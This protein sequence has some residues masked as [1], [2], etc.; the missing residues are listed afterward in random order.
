MFIQVSRGVALR[1]T[2]MFVR[3]V[4]RDVALLKL[5]VTCV[6][7]PVDYSRLKTDYTSKPSCFSPPFLL[8][9]LLP[10]RASRT[11]IIKENANTNSTAS[12]FG[13]AQ[14]PASH[15]FCGSSSLAPL[16]TFSTTSHY[17]CAVLLLLLLC[18]RHVFAA[19]LR[20]NGCYA[21]HPLSGCVS[22][23]SS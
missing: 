9:R 20:E 11:S 15:Y 21:N 17:H 2:C 6:P 3:Q 1:S 8:A 10:H 7:L 19:N 18:L 13:Q 5:R 23:S 12:E 16:R 14:T 4:L 22:A